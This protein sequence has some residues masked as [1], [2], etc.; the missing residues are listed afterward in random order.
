MSNPALVR[1]GWGGLLAAVFFVTATVINLLAPVQTPY[2]STTD[3]VHQTALV[4]AFSC[5]FGAIVGLATLLR[6]SGRFPRL[7]VLGAVLA[8]GGYVGVGLLS[9]VNLIQGERTLVMVRVAASLV[10]LVGSALLGVLVLVTRVLPWWCG[11]L[12]IIAFPLGDAVNSLFPG[13]EGI[14][15]ALLWGSVGAALLVRAG[16]RRDRPTATNRKEVPA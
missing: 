10:L 3:Y 12:L 14:L 9:L 1:G 7:A 11:V 2:V 5:A 8:G 4:L 16:V 13:G 6:A 15:L